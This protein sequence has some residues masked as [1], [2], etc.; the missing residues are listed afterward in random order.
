VRERRL[1]HNEDPMPASLAPLPAN[2]LIPTRPVA[3]WRPGAFIFH[4]TAVVALVGCSDGSSSAI[5]SAATNADAGPLGTTDV[6]PAADSV[7]PADAAADVAADAGEPPSGA[8]DA[9]AAEVGPADATPDL[10]VVPAPAPYPRPSYQRLSE[11]GFYSDPATKTVAADLVGFHPAHVLWSDAAEKRRYVRLPS[12]TQVDT[13]DM[14]HWRFPVGTKF[15]KQFD[16]EGIPVETRLIERYGNGPDDVWMGAF[17][18][19]ADGS[20][21][22][23]A[24]DGATNIRGTQHDAPAAKLCGSCHRGDAGRILGFSALQ[25]SHQG[26]DLNF[27]RLQQAGRLSHPPPAGTVY[28]VPGDPTTAAAL[29]Y[30]HAN[31]GHCHNPM[32]TSWPDTG[33][34]L[35]LNVGERVAETSGIWNSVVGKPLEHW[36]SPSYTMRVVAGAPDMSALVARTKIRGTNDQMPPLATEVVDPT[37][38]ALVTAW[39]AAISQ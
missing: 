36:H 24:V 33:M 39:V 13:S 29:G 32:G 38:V 6:A 20:D 26:D 7:S 19:D 9:L 22:V 27:T 8:A 1:R 34:V 28:S 23:F 25:L 35:R 37:G 10:P 15:F 4:L 5:G 18:W 17:V 2:S 14:D 12:G 21:A 16:Q 30:L 3:R 11:T 31:C